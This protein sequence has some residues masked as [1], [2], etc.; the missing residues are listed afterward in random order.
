[1]KTIKRR[2]IVADT[3]S[4]SFGQIVTE[5][6][7]LEFTTYIGTVDEMVQASFESRRGVYVE[8]SAA[9]EHL[10]KKWDSESRYVVVCKGEPDQYA[11]SLRDIDGAGWCIP[12]FEI[13]VI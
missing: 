11:R 13:E 5:R 8:R 9:T 10:F 6:D 2:E 3:H 1:M 7:N 4:N 12:R